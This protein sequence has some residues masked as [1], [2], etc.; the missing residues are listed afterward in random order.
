MMMFA[1]AAEIKTSGTHPVFVVATAGT[2]KPFW[3]AKLKEIIKAGI[4]RMEPA[5]KF[6]F[7]DW[8]IFYHIWPPLLR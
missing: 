6:N 5:V 8:E 1:V 2:F 4:L 3:P 7:V